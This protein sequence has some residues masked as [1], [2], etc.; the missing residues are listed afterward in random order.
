MGK[1]VMGF[2]EMN[3]DDRSAA[4]GKG[5]MLSALYCMGYPVPEGFVIMPS[6][7]T[8]EQLSSQAWEDIK[9]RL[10]QLRKSHREP[11]FAVRS[12]AL[13][14]DSSEASFAREFE[15]VLNVG[16]DEDILKAVYTVHQSKYAH[17][18]QVY[19]S[20]KGMDACTPIAVVVQVM[21][22]SEISGVLFTA[23]PITGSRKEMPGNFVYGLGEQLVSGES[24]AETF[25]LLR[26][27]GKYSGP[28]SFKK[29]ALRLRKY[30][31]KLEKEL[32]EPQDIEWAM[33]DGKVYILQTRPM[34][35]LSAGNRDAYEINDALT[36]D[37]LWTNTNVGESISGVMTPLTWSI[38]RMLDEEHNLLPGHYVLS[39]NICGRVYSNISYS[40]SMFAA[41]GFSPQMMQNKMKRVFGNIPA[42]MDIPLFPFSKWNL[43]RMLLPK[44]FYS[45]Q[46]TKEAV[47]SIDDFIAETPG[48]CREMT[49][50]IQAAGSREEL[51]A[52]WVTEI[53]PYNVKGMW[54]ALEAPSQAMQTF[55]KLYA[56]LS[57]RVGEE[58][59]GLI[60]SNIEDLELESLGP[61]L[62]IPKVIKGEM[63]R[64]QYIEKYGHRGP[65]EVELSVPEPS[66]DPA[67]LD[68]QMSE[69]QQMLTDGGQLLENRK[70]KS[71]RAWE[72]FER[73]Y[74]RMAKRLAAK[75]EAALKGPKIREAVRSEW[76]RTS[77]VNRVFA[78]KAGELAGMGDDVFF[79]YL[80]EILAWLKE[81]T[82]NGIA[83]LPA[84][85]ENY[86]KYQKLPPLPTI[87][88]GRFEPFIW[89]KDPERRLDF[90]D[91]SLP[92]DDMPY[93]CLKGFPGS[94][95]R[96]K[97]K[98]RILDNLDDGYQLQPGE[99]L[100]ASTLNIGWTLI[101]PK[102][103]AIITDIGAPL[104]HAAIVARELG[105]PA[106]VGCGSATSVLK[107]GD[108][109]IV[110]GGQ[111]IVQIA[112]G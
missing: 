12:S 32:G 22:R 109:V 40:L 77:R 59:A 33:A 91:A 38:L 69:Y 100:V 54:I 80:D 18:V 7:F 112:A 93:D 30:A 11:L 14:E 2:A 104:S 55:E 31:C 10:H 103:A 15:T 53:W 94:S 25:A 8:G 1:M 84:R 51:D 3:A 49:E 37:F 43:F 28:E 20:A 73:Q 36:G 75:I 81:G 42:G 52:L 4:G 34:T 6:A 85:K 45:L 71:V 64:E 48:W 102:A 60:L 50:R 107:T 47:R 79:L 98:V 111:G 17:R 67:W 88:R 65:Q 105:I 63:S 5:A 97:G 66:E 101:F 106:V 58:E 44:I 56:K 23:D 95:G 72:Q 86:A 21:V 68:N 13:G 90:Y 57:K 24:N 99:I 82:L 16:S 19:S 29:Y 76:T 61:L 78:L 70:I 83:H 35:T 110:D 87:I 74:P 46:R 27:K 26:S 62:G 89:A 9:Y 92:P 41:F 39:G 108:L 96:V